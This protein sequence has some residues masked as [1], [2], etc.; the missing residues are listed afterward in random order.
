M[1]I[2]SGGSEPVVDLTEKIFSVRGLRVMLDSDLA[3]IYGVTTKRLNEQIKRNL[4]RFPLDF[5][6]VLTPEEFQ[7]L[8]SQIA[9]SSFSHGGRRSLPMAFTEYGAIMAANVLKS[10]RAADMSVFV[11]RAFVRMRELLT[12]NAT[13]SAKL[14]ELEKK[15]ASH[16][17]SISE[18]ISA[19]RELINPTEPTIPKRE[20][21][22]HVKNSRNKL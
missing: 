20:I 1:A 21:G 5:A 3:A 19:L 11:V 2:E 8:K 6:F 4:K 15:V 17:D 10:D 16:D 7:N 14:S 13:L 18:I 12:S 9:T 22:F